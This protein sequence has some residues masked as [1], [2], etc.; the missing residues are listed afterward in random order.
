[1][2]YK[3]LLELIENV[4]PS[5]TAKLDE[6]DARCLAL[7]FGYKFESFGQSKINPNMKCLKVSG[8]RIDEGSVCQQHLIPQYTRSRDAL[9]SI[10]PEGW[11]FTIQALQK[12]C[13]CTAQKDKNLKWSNSLPTEELTE[14]HAIIQSIQWERENEN[15][16]L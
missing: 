1:M 9:K 5:D 15:S 13:G 3:E 14:L 16:N 12:A 6:I 11:N 7:F 2:N 8:N 10:R 4:D